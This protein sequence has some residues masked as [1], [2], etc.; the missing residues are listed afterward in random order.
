MKDL[1]IFGDSFAAETTNS[2]IK[3]FIEYVPVLDHADR[4]KQQLISYHQLLRASRQFNSVTSY[5]IAGDDLWNQFRLFQYHYTGKE[6]VVFFETAPGRITSNN[7]TVCS[8]LATVN[9][10]QGLI[11]RFER[12]GHHVPNLDQ[13]KQIHNAAFEYFLHLQR[14]DFDQFVNQQIVSQIRKCV[15]DLVVIP[16]FPSSSSYAGHSLLDISNSEF[17]P[18]FSASQD[19]VELRR[20]HLTEE[21]HY[22]LADQIVNYFRSKKP[23]DFELFLRAPNADIDQY[24]MKL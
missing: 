21:N 15:D 10:T 4:L 2:T 16:C 17:D 18:N 22:I 14:D 6:S 8:N 19:F 5:G 23:V 24:F 11:K 9:L 1:L 20:N 12:F 3:Q 13:F 7:G